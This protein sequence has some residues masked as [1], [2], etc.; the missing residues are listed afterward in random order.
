MAELI[1]AFNIGGSEYN[2]NATQIG[3]NSFINTFNR[4]YKTSKSVT[5]TTT[6]TD[7]YVKITLSAYAQPN[8]LFVYCSYNNET[9]RATIDLSGMSYGYIFKNNCQNSGNI[10]GICFKSSYDSTEKKWIFWLKF[11]PIYTDYYSP[12][13]SA[14]CTVYLSDQNDSFDVSATTTDP[15]VNWIT[16]GS[17]NNNIVLKNATLYGSLIGQADYASRL[18]NS[19]GYHTK[20]TIDNALDTK[21]PV[22]GGTITGNLTVNGSI[23]GNYIRGKALYSD[24]GLDLCA[25]GMS[26]AGSRIF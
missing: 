12:S 26:T 9:D 23:F 22:G 6:N 18:G 20:A 8:Q 13:S 7:W 25:Y 15:C 14:T 11:D 3:G 17:D 5:M 16:T 10:K 21:L 24:A 19:N 4:L 2:F 1:K